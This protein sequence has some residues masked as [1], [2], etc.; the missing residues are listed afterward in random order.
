[1]KKLFLTLNLLFCITL[2][3]VAQNNATVKQLGNIN[4]A[5]ISQIY[6]AGASTDINS[7]TITQTGN[8]NKVPDLQQRGAGNRFTITQVGYRNRTSAFTDQGGSDGTAVPSYDGVIEITQIGNENFVDDADQLGTG[9]ELYINQGTDGA[10]GNN[11]YVTVDAQVSIG[12]TGNRIR[13]TQIGDNNAVGNPNTQ[14]GAYQEGSGN[15]MAITQRGGASA[16]KKEE[17]TP[18]EADFDNRFLKSQF[19]GEGLIQLGNNNKLT[20]D[21]NGESSV[22]LVYQNGTGNIAYIM[23][24]GAD[25]VTVVKQVG[26]SNTANITQNGIGNSATIN[27]SN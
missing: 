13:I 7:A 6:Q 9:N 17:F 22:D 27:Q 11:N 4:E 14:A 12:G 23:Q 5:N 8:N 25:N 10:P 21:Q 18:P 24:I 26:L 20:I 15:S 19:G 3:A 2:L 1:M 16:G